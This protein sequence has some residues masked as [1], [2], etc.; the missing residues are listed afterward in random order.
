MRRG[1]R[2]GEHTGGVVLG[3]LLPFRVVLAV[4][5]YFF[6][7][8]RASRIDDFVSAENGRSGLLSLSYFILDGR[9]IGT[10]FNTR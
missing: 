2:G 6:P 5:L 7:C 9:E 10:V 8:G 1:G 4:V 3:N